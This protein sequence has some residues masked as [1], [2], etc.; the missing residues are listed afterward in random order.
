MQ[1]NTH[2]DLQKFKDQLKLESLPER[3]KKRNTLLILYDVD[4]SITANEETKRKYCTTEFRR[5]SSWEG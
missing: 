5:Q 2:S 4:S 3:P 1:F